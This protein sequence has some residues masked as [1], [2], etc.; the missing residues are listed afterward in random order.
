[1]YCAYQT[2]SPSHR[3]STKTHLLHNPQTSVSARNRES[4]CVHMLVCISI[5]A[6]P[7]AQINSLQ[8]LATTAG[9]I[10]AVLMLG[11][12]GGGC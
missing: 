12:S 10:V 7:K 6:L 5:V 1:M 8:R 9:L 11:L 2:P 3:V 4:R